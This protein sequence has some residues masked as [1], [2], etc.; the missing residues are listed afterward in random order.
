MDF[1]LFL[2]FLAATGAAAATGTLFPPGEWYAALTKPWFTPPSIAFPI[3]WTTLYVLMSVAAARVAP[4]QGAQYAMALWALQI[5]LNT[6]WTPV[7]FGLNRMVPGLIIIGILWVVIAAMIV[8]FWRLDRLAGALLLP[9]LGWVTV[10][11]SLTIGLIRLNPE[12]R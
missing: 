5:A 3:V 7:F 2:I 8:A 11:A 12:M 1:A 9:Y 6:L 10:A 4:M